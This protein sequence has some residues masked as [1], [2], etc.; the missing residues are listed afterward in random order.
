MMVATIACQSVG[1]L[2]AAA[3]TL[4][5]LRSGSAQAWR[6]FFAT[7]GAVALLFFVFACRHQKVRIG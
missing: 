1:M 4:F 6:L 5:L 2:L 3:V 7:E